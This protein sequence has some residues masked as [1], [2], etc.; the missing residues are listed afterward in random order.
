MSIIRFIACLCFII[1]GANAFGQEKAVE[2]HCIQPADHSAPAGIYI[3]HV[4]AKKEW[5]FSYRFMQTNMRGNRSGTSTVS[6][7]QIYDNYLMAPDRMIMQMHMLMLMYGLSDKITF[8]GMTSYALNYMGMSMLA[9][10]GMAQ[11]NMSGNNNSMEISSKASGLAD[12]KIYMLYELIA[13]NG[14]ELVLSGGINIPTGKNSLRGKSMTG[15]NDKYSYIMQPGTG[16]FAVLPGITY[17]WKHHIISGGCQLSSVLRTG[18][19]KEHYRWGNEAAFSSWISHN[20]ASW[21]SNSLRADIAVTDKIKGYDPE[22]ASMRSVDPTA[23]INNYGGVRST[24]YGGINIKI[25]NGLLKGLRLS[26]EYGLPVYQNLNGL[27]I[28]LKSTLYTSLQYGF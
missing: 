21:I 10:G 3:D 6:T 23:D 26:A 25:S 28:S 11:M 4:H 17:T 8:M 16:N 19:N 9:N 22:I 13:K 2:C 24:F 5:M 1:I 12:T 20:W 14:H 7:D 15:K 27:Q 18:N